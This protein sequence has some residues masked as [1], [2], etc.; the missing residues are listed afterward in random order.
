M[1]SSQIEKRTTKPIEKKTTKNRDNLPSH[2][3]PGRYVVPIAIGLGILAFL[4]IICT[5]VNKI[6]RLKMNALNQRIQLNARPAGSIASL[7]QGI[8]FNLARS[9][10]SSVLD[11]DETNFQKNE[12][13]FGLPSYEDVV[14]EKY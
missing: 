9:T 8:Q 14:K 1:C 4:L 7:N 11:M 2:S 3:K 13:N 10:V 12:D 6:K 5:L